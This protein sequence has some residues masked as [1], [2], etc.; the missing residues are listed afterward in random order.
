VERCE[1][2][3]FA[4]DELARDA[5]VVALRQVAERYIERLAP[6]PGA[7]DVAHE[8]RLRAHPIAG[9]WSALEYACHVRDVLVVELDRIEQAQ[10][11][12]QPEFVPMGRDERV[13]RD[14]YNEQEP[15]TVARQ[16]TAAAGALA[17]Y[18]DVL[19]DRGWDRTGIYGYPTRQARTVTWMADHTVHELVHHLQDID[20]LLATAA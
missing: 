3:D 5:I 18:L 13:E 10:A 8:L 15:A 7:P 17:T 11:E 20:D 4:Y 16:I 14:R 2:C 9:V 19:D 1:Q 6:A 12:D